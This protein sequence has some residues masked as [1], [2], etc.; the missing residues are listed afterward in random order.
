MST[1]VNRPGPD[2]FW[3]GVATAAYQIEGGAREDGRGRSIWDTF[4]ERLGVIADGSSGAVACDSYHRWTEDLD[5]VAGLGADAYRFSI[6]WP[7]IQPDG[8]GPANPAGLAYYDR[9]VDGMLERGVAPVATLFHWDLPQA[10]Q[11]DGGWME[12]G[13]AERFAEYAA[14]VADALGDRVAAWC[15]LNEPFVHMGFGYAFGI[16]APGEARMLDAFAAGHHQL[17]GHGLATSALRTASDA[18]VALVNNCTP[19][20]AA[21]DSD[22]DGTAAAAYD[23]F[24]NGMFLDPVLLG[25]YPDALA[26]LADGVVRDGD[27]TTIAQPLDLLGINYYNPT[28]IA[29]PEGDDPLPFAIVP[30]EGVPRTGFDWPVVPSGLTDLLVGL[31]D[32]YGAALPPILVTENG[33]A[34]PDGADAPPYDDVERIG[35]LDGHIAAVGAAREVGV[36]VRGYFCWSLLD[37]FEWAEGFTQRFGLVHLDLATQDRTPRASYGWYRDRIARAWS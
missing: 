19:V 24:H 23:A 28:R 4:C 20:E 7:R 31:R 10:L 25:R 18:P 13:T 29:A 26:A 35:F 6:A 37:N 15:T 14:L 34:Y 5:L 21:S 17:L 3:W 12:R 30:I 22:E 32:R 33:C 2:D 9:L 27:L 8:R 16:H 36:D 1:A 11:D